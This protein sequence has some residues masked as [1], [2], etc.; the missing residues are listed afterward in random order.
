MS[1]SIPESLLL[2]KRNQNNSGSWKHIQVIWHFR[3]HCYLVITNL[4]ESLVAP[5]TQCWI[6]I[7][8]FKRCQWN[9]LSPLTFYQLHKNKVPVALKYDRNNTRHQPISSFRNCLLFCFPTPQIPSWS[10]SDL[11]E[12]F[13]YSAE[14]KMGEINDNLAVKIILSIHIQRNQYTIFFQTLRTLFGDM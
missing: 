2:F 8:V 14:H 12:L 7:F 4:E 3:L 1:I 11:S 5:D 13:N 6:S 10:I 9:R